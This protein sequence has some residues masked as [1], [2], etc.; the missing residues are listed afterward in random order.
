MCICQYYVQIL[1]DLA[2]IVV[3]S[4]NYNNNSYPIHAS[5]AELTLLLIDNTQH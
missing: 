1:Q 4:Y 2:F 5:E 3:V